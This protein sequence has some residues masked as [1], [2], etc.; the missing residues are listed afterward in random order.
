MAIHP[1]MLQPRPDRLMP[2]LQPFAPKAK[3]LPKNHH[4][5]LRQVPSW[6][7]VPLRVESLQPLPL[8]R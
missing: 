1:L 2:P 7:D 4:G 6:R 5:R 3:A 8:P